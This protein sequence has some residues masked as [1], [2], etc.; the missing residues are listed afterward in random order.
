MT[1]LKDRHV[2]TECLADIRLQCASPHARSA[3]TTP[4]GDVHHQR[5][6]AFARAVFHFH[7]SCI[8]AVGVCTNPSDVLKVRLQMQNE[9]SKK[10]AAGAAAA[11]LQPQQQLNLLQMA[12]RMIRTEGW[13]SLMNGWQASVMRE[14]SYS[15]IRMGLYD[16]VKQVLAG[17]KD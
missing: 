6:K 14:M 16:E 1:S 5:V 8:V 11:A 3:S 9:L 10:A 17:V 7:S 15:A 2:T 12:R 13:S 4:S